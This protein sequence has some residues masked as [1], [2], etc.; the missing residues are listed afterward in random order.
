MQ[1]ILSAAAIYLLLLVVFRVAGKRTLKEVTVF[2]FVLLLIIGEAT[3]E[4]LLGDDASWTNAALVISTLVAIDVA[5]SLVKRRSRKLEMALDDV[6]LVLVDR[7]V[8]I[9][10]HLE[11]ERIDEEDILEAARR[12]HGLV[13]LDQVEYAVLERGGEIAIVPRD[14]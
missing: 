12:L 9:R 4:T 8:P 11:K 14:R 13:R 5:L 7:G 10:E 2:D 3:Q 1:S 6:P